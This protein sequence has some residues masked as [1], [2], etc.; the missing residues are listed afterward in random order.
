[1][2]PLVSAIRDLTQCQIDPQV[3]RQRRGRL[4]ESPLASCHFSVHCQ[5][6]HITAAV[7]CQTA[8][9]MPR[10]NSSRRRGK[11]SWFPE[12][13]VCH[14]CETTKHCCGRWVECLRAS[15]RC[16][17]PWACRRDRQLP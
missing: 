13:P 12:F 4:E 2:I 15:R 5:G 8:V 6:P 7:V 10:D 1:M 11:K 16:S 3:K 9:R 14:N 17:Q